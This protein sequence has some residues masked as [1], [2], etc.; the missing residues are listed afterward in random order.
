MNHTRR[1]I[2]VEKRKLL[3]VEG[4]DE[5]L[6]FGAMLKE[7]LERDDVQV[8]GIGGK[9]LIADNL[10]ALIRDPRYPE[11][12]TIAVIRDANTTPDASQVRA[13]RSAWQSVT[14]AMQNAAIPTSDEHGKFA[15]GPPRSG[16]FILPDGQQDGMLETLCKRAIHGQPVSGCLERYFEC[17]SKHE[18]RQKNADKAWVH[19]YLASCK[20][21]DKRLGEAAQAG[22]WAWNAPAFRTIIAF[23]AA[24]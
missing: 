18:I 1:M 14:S 24:M 6:F 19:A 17:L 11:V 16:I 21:P 5:E 7:H 8:M 2:R 15:P 23:I 4:R 10:Q 13:A 3:I 20:E 22:Y 12:E 9:T